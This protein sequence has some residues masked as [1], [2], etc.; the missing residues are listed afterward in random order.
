MTC[1]RGG[2]V[3]TTVVVTRE[4]TGGPAKGKKEKV[5]R[6]IFLV[7]VKFR[8]WPTGLIGLIRPRYGPTDY[9]APARRLCLVLARRLFGVVVVVSGR[10]NAHTVPGGSMMTPDCLAWTVAP[11]GGMYPCTTRYAG[12]YLEYLPAYSHRSVLPPTHRLSLWCCAAG[13]AALVA[14]APLPTGSGRQRIL[15]RPLADGGKELVCRTELPDHTRPVRE[16][17]FSLNHTGGQTVPL[18]RLCGH[19]REDSDAACI[20]YNMYPCFRMYTS[21]QLF[22][23]RTARPAICLR[24]TYVLVHKRARGA[25]GV[26]ALVAPA[27]GTTVTS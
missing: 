22:S 5:D 4:G 21:G 13:L 12:M 8:S 9:T 1:A 20:A 26:A 25:G 18:S 14:L 3:V 15:L 2:L 10:R 23:T 27:A 7:K 6:A 16:S 24:L 11:G 17:S 19:C